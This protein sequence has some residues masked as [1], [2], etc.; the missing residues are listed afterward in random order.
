MYLIGLGRFVTEAVDE[1]LRLFYHPLLVLIGCSLLRHTFL[2]ELNILAVRDFVV[3]HVAQHDLDCAVCHIVE[4]FAVVR[5]QQN[6]TAEILQVSLEPF[7][8]LDVKVVCRFVKQQHIRSAE[9]DLGKLDTHVP[10][11]AESLRLAREFV[12]LEAETHQD[13]GRLYL[14][15]FGMTD[16]E[17]VVQ[18]IQPRDQPGIFSRLIISPFR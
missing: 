9:E 3:I 11:L 17:M 2:T 4:E 6:G 13:A 10:A 12:V 7:D 14:W 8:R 16:G 1:F 18:I 15:R 5:D